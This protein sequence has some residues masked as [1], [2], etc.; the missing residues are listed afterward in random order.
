MFFY[1]LLLGSKY[2]TSIKNFL[3]VL[4]SQKGIMMYLQRYSFTVKAFVEL[5]KSMTLR[6]KMILIMLLF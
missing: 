3:N 4:R 2:I 6:L 5:V 1:S